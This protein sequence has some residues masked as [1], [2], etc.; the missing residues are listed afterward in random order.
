MKLLKLIILVFTVC[1]SVNINAQMTNMDKA[2]LYFKLAQDQ[3]NAKNY[4]GAL[5]YISKTEQEIIEFRSKDSTHIKDSNHHKD[6]SSATILNLKIKTL[7]EL[8]EH[9]KLHSEFKKFENKYI[10]MASNEL[11]TETFNYYAKSEEKIKELKKKNHE[12]EWKGGVIKLFEY[13]N[14]ERCQGAGNY[15]ETIEKYGKKPLFKKDKVVTCEICKGKGIRL[16]YNGNKEELKD[17]TLQEF[18]DL[19][20]NEINA[21]SEQKYDETWINQKI[22]LYAHNDSYEINN[23]NS[24]KL[25]YKGNNKKLKELTRKGFIVL[26][27]KEIKEYLEKHNE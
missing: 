1:F 14:C 12:I 19:Y 26:F 15:S 10:I 9:K 27:D 25:D 6:S 11:K 21:S 22:K 5:Q 3:F 20:Q 16:I 7:Y 2:K 23:D 8:N 4:K 24:L 17:S 18:K 13:V